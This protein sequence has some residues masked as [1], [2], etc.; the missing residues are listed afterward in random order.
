MPLPARRDALDDPLRPPY[1]EGTSGA[2]FAA[3]CF[4]GAEKAFWQIPGVVTTTLGSGAGHPGPGGARRPSAWSS[5]KVPHPL[6]LEL[7]GELHNPTQLM[8]Q[9]NDAGS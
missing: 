8:Q 3:G 2:A 9:G 1:P 4:W 5:S 7:F 6:L